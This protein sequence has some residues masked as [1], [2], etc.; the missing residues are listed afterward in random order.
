MTYDDMNK[1]LT[2]SMGVLLILGGILTLVNQRVKGPALVIMS[3]VLMIV[4]QDNPWI[5]EQ[6]KPK[7]KTAHIRYNDLFRHLSLI[8]AC[9]YV[10]VTPPAEDEEKKEDEGAKVKQD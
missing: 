7:P 2:L 3:V 6:I 9:L 8:G 4:T 5:R 10:M 1:Y